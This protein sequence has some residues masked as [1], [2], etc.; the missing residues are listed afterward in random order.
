MVRS[1]EEL[2]AFCTQCEHR[3]KKMCHRGGACEKCSDR[4][5]CIDI[6]ALEKRTGRK[7]AEPPRR[8]I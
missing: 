3:G 4:Y 8:Y 7:F 6:C 5:E 1:K 2:D